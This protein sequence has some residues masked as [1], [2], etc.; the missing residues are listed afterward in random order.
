MY[1]GELPGLEW[2]EKKRRYFAYSKNLDEPNIT[3]SFSS[4]AGFSS[5]QAGQVPT[6]SPVIQSLKHSKRGKLFTCGVCLD[7]KRERVQ[8]PCNH[9]FC[10][11]CLTTWLERKGHC[12]TCRQV[13]DVALHT[14]EMAARTTF[15]PISST[16]GFGS[17]DAE[18]SLRGNGSGPSPFWENPT[19]AQEEQM[20]SSLGIPIRTASL[21]SGDQ[22]SGTTSESDSDRTNSSSEEEGPASSN[23]RPRHGSRQESTPASKSS[24]ARRNSTTKAVAKSSASRKSASSSSTLGPANNTSRRGAPMK[25]RKE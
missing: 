8:L 18:T 7:E 14:A 4:G 15:K 20:S 23:S 2:D 13:V 21:V 3:P 12:P 16:Q 6:A 11:P 24:K 25:R 19:Y 10:P 22:C 17:F 9:L 5:L 1:K